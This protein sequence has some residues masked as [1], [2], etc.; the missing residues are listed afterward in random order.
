[1][2]STTDQ[3][4]TTTTDAQPEASL[5]EL[6]ADLGFEVTA[7]KSWYADIPVPMSKAFGA[8]WTRCS[9]QPNNYRI[10]ANVPNGTATHHVVKVPEVKATV[11]PATQK[12]TKPGRPAH[13]E[14]VTNA[15]YFALQVKTYA[16]MHNLA[17]TADV[18]GA[19][20]SFRFASRRDPS[21]ANGPITVS[22]VAERAAE[23][24]A[25]ANAATAVA[26]SAAQSAA[27]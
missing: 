13:D 23:S 9:A 15:E 8:A 10:N 1:M 18:N 3:P 25:G 14:T 20:V 2:T 24:E 4:I 17:H 22:S 5:E 19:T 21:K 27:K 12:I 11:D 7:R 6:F 26:E 16:D